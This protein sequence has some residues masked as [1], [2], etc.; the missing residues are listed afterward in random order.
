MFGAY[1]F[2]KNNERYFSIKQ[3]FYVFGNVFQNGVNALSKIVFKTSIFF[4]QKAQN[5][6]QFRPLFK[7]R[8]QVVQKLV[9]VCI[10]RDFRLPMSALATVAGKNFNGKCTVQIDFS[11]RILYTPSLMLTLEMLEVY[12]VSPY[13]FDKYLDHMLLKFEQNHMIQT[14]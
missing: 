9:K 3:L 10:W 12:M 7:F 2:F 6:V 5:F 8:Q 14:V 13:S 11:D 4:L 1:V